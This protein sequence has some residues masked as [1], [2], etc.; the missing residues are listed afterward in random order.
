[1]SRARLNLIAGPDA[2]DDALKFYQTAAAAVRRAAVLVQF[3]AAAQRISIRFA[4]ADACRKTS[5][6]RDRSKDIR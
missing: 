3:G 4:I 5:E 6:V 2:S 1:M